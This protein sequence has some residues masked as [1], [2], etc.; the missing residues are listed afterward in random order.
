MTFTQ[1]GSVDFYWN[2]PTIGFNPKSVIIYVEG[3]YGF[4]PLIVGKGL[5]GKTQTAIE[6]M[7]SYQSVEPFNQMPNTMNPAWTITQLNRDTVSIAIS[8]WWPMEIDLDSNPEMWSK[9]YPMLRDIIIFLKQHGTQSLTFFTCMNNQNADENS[10]LLV[11]DMHN[12]FRPTQ[13]LILA[14]PAWIA[15]F[16]AHRLGIRS[17]VVAATQDE[18]L[19]VDDKALSLAKE[20]FMAL[21][22]SW[23]E[24]RAQNTRNTLKNME[25][26]LTS[27]RFLIDD[28]DEG[29]WLA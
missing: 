25:E 16:I 23:D 20:Y 13:D 3:E 18:G 1:T 15:P 12:D 2:I 24:E 6:I 4:I 11:Y 21:G 28:D 14:P 5:E 9:A 29:G 8:N 10:E 17:A 22:L 7:S 27:R 19:F 26:D